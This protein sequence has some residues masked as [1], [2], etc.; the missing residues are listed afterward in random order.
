MT[1]RILLL[2]AIAMIGWLLISPPTHNI[3]AQVTN[4]PNCSYVITFPTGS[5]G[6]TF[7][8][9]QETTATFRMGACNVTSTQVTYVPIAADN[10][11]NLYDIGIADT[12]GNL[13]THIGATAGTTFAP[14]TT[15]VTRPWLTTIT[16][17]AN[18]EY[19][20]VRTTNC[21]ASCATISS[22][23]SSPILRIANANGGATSN[24]VLVS[25]TPP[26]TNFASSAAPAWVLW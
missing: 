23:G 7:T 3:S 6:Q 16:L 12:A 21:A 17:Q 20:L 15:A 8:L 24:G 9:N 2:V 26:A 18:V 25:I 11:G 19:L 1:R 13:L 22:G 10:T 14:S 5:N 4:P